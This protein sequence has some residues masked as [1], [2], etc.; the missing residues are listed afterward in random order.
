MEEDLQRK[1][2]KRH[3]VN[4][5]TIHNPSTVTI[6]EGVEIKAGANILSSSI[7]VGHSVI[8]KNAIIGPFASISNSL[9]GNSAIVKYSS[10]EDSII[11]DDESIGPYK[12]IKNKE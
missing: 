10:V 7:I 4:G 6:G 1:I 8:E 11:K 2:I 12:T 3:L 5:V 9:I